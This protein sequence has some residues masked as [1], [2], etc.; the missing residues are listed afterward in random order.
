MHCDANAHDASAKDELARSHC[1]PTA[2]YAPWFQ[3]VLKCARLAVSVLS[4]LSDEACSQS[5]PPTCT[6]QSHIYKACMVESC[7]PH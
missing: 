4:M 3:V 5:L 7:K 1:R 2:A 6:C